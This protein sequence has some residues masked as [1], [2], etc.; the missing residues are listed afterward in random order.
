MNVSHFIHL[1]MKN[2]PIIKK[3]EITD[4][5]NCQI[6]VYKIS[7]IPRSQILKFGSFFTI[8]GIKP[9]SC[10]FIETEKESK[11]GTYYDKSIK[12]EISKIRPE[13]SDVLDPFSNRQVAAIVTDGN[14]Y[15][16]LVYPLFRQTKR[17]IPGTPA[18]ANVTEVEFSGQGIYESPFVV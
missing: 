1:T 12:F 8:D 13:V 14:D 17:N 10:S 2:L 3:I 11:A 6:P 16:Y 9:N 4:L 15:S 5:R 7:R 18:K